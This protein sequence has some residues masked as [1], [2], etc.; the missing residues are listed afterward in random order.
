MGDLN[1]RLM[2]A[3]LT[4]MTASV[5][6]DLKP[7][8]IAVIDPIGQRTFFDLNANPNRVVRLLRA[9]GVVAGDAV[10][11]LCSNRAEFVEV[12]SACLRGGFRITPVNWH[13]NPEEVEYI[14][15]DCEAKALFV[16]GRFP[17]G[18]AAKAPLVQVKVVIDGEAPGFLPYAETLA[19]I[20][21]SDIADPIM[22]QAMLYTSGTTGRP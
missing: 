5:W 7:D 14:I 18:F 21:G 9:H 12:L 3:A 13:L 15:N 17:A 19:G 4:G 11:L 16:D 8:E 22:G 1:A 10:A 20:D 6:A 2:E